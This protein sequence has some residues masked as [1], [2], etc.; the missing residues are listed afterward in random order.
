MQRID[1]M[2]APQPV[3]PKVL[4]AKAY[5]ENFEHNLFKSKADIIVSNPSDVTYTSILVAVID[6]DKNGEAT[7]T[8]QIYFE[9]IAPHTEQRKSITLPP[10]VRNLNCQIIKF[11]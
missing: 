9:Q 7:K 10:R 3:Y 6:F 2:I 5:S 11:E 1:R 8:E 4:W